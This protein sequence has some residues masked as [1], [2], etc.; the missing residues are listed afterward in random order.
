MDALVDPTHP[1][2]AE[3]AAWVADVTGSDTPF[4]LGLPRH[5]AVNRT[6]AQQFRRTQSGEKR[7][8]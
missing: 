7:R 2:H 1:D 6:L 4:D 8:K 5:P 3:H